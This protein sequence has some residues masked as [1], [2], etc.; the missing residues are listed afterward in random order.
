VLLLFLSQNLK[1]PVDYAMMQCTGENSTMIVD[2]IQRCVLKMSKGCYGEAVALLD[3]A[4]QDLKVYFQD[5]ASNMASHPVDTDL[6]ISV[7]TEQRVRAVVGPICKTAPM[8]SY[9]H[10]SDFSIFDR[11]LLIQGANETDVWSSEVNVAV[12][13]AV[14]LYN[15]GLCFH[16][17]GQGDA[18]MLPVEKF[19]E[20]ARFLYEKAFHL[21]V[22]CSPCVNDDF[23]I[24][25][26]LLNNL[27]QITSY[28]CDR[29]GE[30]LFLINLETL[31]IARVDQG[32]DREATLNDEVN[33]S[34]NV[35]LFC[36]FHRPAPAA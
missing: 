32:Y 14:I 10:L 11:A 9:G 1:L 30:Q 20:K 2:T 17:L 3:S 8:E 16:I 5:Q 4:L 7:E 29:L 18:K 22:T 33:L 21:M 13:T 26:A 19:I 15:K 25:S 24:K 34:L 23:W 36:G 31:L 35:I 6:C 27:G 12:T 28:T